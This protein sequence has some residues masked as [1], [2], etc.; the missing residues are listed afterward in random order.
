M[1][2]A[3]LGAGEAVAS[4]FP[5]IEVMAMKRCSICRETMPVSVMAGPVCPM[6]AEEHDEWGV[7]F[8][9]GQEEVDEG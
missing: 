3:S 7:Y 4:V 5:D 9:L 8:C 2:G 1:E 6:C